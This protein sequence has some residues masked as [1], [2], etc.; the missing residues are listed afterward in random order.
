VLLLLKIVISCWAL[1]VFLSTKDSLYWRKVWNLVIDILVDLY[2]ISV[3]VHVANIL[4]QKSGENAPSYPSY[5]QEMS[6]GVRSV[7]PVGY[8]PP[9]FIHFF[10]QNFDLTSK[11]LITVDIFLAMH[12]LLSLKI[13]AFIFSA[14]ADIDDNFNTPDE[15]KLLPTSKTAFGDHRTSL[16]FVEDTVFRILRVVVGFLGLHVLRRYNQ[17]AIKRILLVNISLVSLSMGIYFIL[18]G[19]FEELSIPDRFY[20]GSF[21]L[22]LAF[23]MIIL[24]FL[25]RCV[26]HNR[27]VSA[28]G[29]INY[30]ES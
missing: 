19:L 12:A 26:E 23:R 18:F 14:V 27:V 6:E 8:D 29:L 10:L 24:Y 7:V 2:F 25:T 30:V 16:I 3:A 17:E 9:R 20:Q 22:N 28:N 1:L 4:W 15:S 21:T 11:L 13:P 5:R